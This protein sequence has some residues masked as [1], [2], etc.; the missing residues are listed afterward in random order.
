[1]ISLKPSARPL[2]VGRARGARIPGPPPVLEN[3]VARPWESARVEPPEVPKKPLPSRGRSR[4]ARSSR[5]LL[6]QL[7]LRAALEEE[8]AVLRLF[9][10][11]SRAT[12]GRSQCSWASGK[13]EGQT[14]WAADPHGGVAVLHPGA[15]AV[16][17]LRRGVVG[18]VA[19]EV[20]A[21]AVLPGG[22][23][24]RTRSPHPKRIALPAG[25]E[26]LLD[27]RRIG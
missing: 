25:Q 24:P 9:A 27:S 17:D 7:H 14:T 3:F 16:H 4:R 1:M 11:F 2:D 6:G 12:R 23:R 5:L 13:R 20:A 10:F 21:A 18:G 8:V 22:G 26:R 19:V 15:D